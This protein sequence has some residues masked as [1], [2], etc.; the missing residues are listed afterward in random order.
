[1][2]L[3][4][5]LGATTAYET[6]YVMPDGRKDTAPYCGVALARFF[7]DTTMRVFVTEKAREMHYDQFKELVED[8]VAD[9]EPVDISDGQN[10]TELWQIFQAVV[11]NV[12]ENEK[13]IFDVT[14]GFR[15]LPFLSFLAAAYLRVVKDIDLEAVL[16][17]NFEARDKTVEPNRAPVIDM[18]DFVSLLDWM[19]AADRFVRF[20]DAHDL[21]DQLRSAKPD[22]KAQQA[23]VDVRDEAMRLGQA[24]R[25]LDDVSLSLRL[26][27]PAEAMVA[28]AQLQTRLTDATASAQQYA[29]PF[30]P[31][32]QQVTDAYAPLAL[33]QDEQKR[34]PAAALAHERR[35]VQWYLKRS[36]FVQALAV[37]REWIVSWAMIY[38]KMLP[39]TEKYNRDE[40]ER[41][42]GKAN[43]QRRQNR[44]A[45]DDYTFSTGATLRSLPRASDALK[46]YKLVGDARNDLLHAGK[47][48]A[49]QAAN[50]MEKNIRRLCVQ[51]DQLPLPQ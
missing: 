28:S 42:F 46:L 6:T 38:L 50:E 2:K 13:V 21:A 40:V 18:T 47:R 11:D 20:G 22:F 3:L 51:L 30:I 39:L 15:S 10:E 16:Y 19:V 8:Y 25:A 1:M 33:S 48:P 27:R 24:A 5:F 43:D 17:G 4:T 41:A 31:L 23:S 36:Q 32:S 14:H 45:Y 12:G 37:A 34:D 49:P 7:P 44:G 26:I 29:L 9:V 35:M